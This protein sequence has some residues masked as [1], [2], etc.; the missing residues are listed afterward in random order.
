MNSK[1]LVDT[2]LDGT[3][4]ASF[5]KEFLTNSAHF[6][7][8]NLILECLLEDPKKYFLEP[9]AYILIMAALFQAFVLTYLR[10]KKIGYTFLG[11]LIGPIVYVLFEFPLEGA[12]FFSAPQ[13]HAYWYFALSI[14][15][16]QY[17]K[18]KNLLQIK[19]LWEILEN[20]IRTLIPLAMYMLFEA[21]NKDFLFSIPH[22]FSDPAHIFLSIVLFLLGILLGFSEDQNT[23]NKAEL[24]ALTKQLKNY[25]SW[26]LGN[27]ILNLA[28][29]NENIFSIKRVDRAILFLDIRG[30]TKW[31]ENES[32]ENVVN[33][34]NEYYLNAEKLIIHLKKLKIKYTA[35]KIMIVFEDVD[36]AGIAS[37]IL[38]NN[39]NEQLA[40]YQ[41]SVGGGLHVG[42]VVEG[43]IGSLDHKIFDV[44]GDTVNTTK[45]FCDNAKGAEILV[46][47]EFISQSNGK[48][49]STSSREVILK[50][51]E[52]PHLVFTLLNYFT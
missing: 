4:L 1:S 38:R 50:G 17:G 20:M 43:L 13:H 19:S 46:S 42:P 29:E 39:L 2:K 12:K 6:P 40:Q 18:E 21:H 22:F 14:G 37:V 44:M 45:R 27:Q 41:L 34:L 11:N 10:K 52:K 33:M 49:F 23:K 31:S 47:S 16:F 35:D 9:D 24:M 36:S 28:I 7:I 5:T 48:V 15:F 32:P 25:S 3:F 8:T 51:K 30:F 26:S